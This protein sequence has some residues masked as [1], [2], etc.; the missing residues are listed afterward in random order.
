MG[1]AVTAFEATIE[2]GM[3]N[4]NGSCLSIRFEANGS[5]LLS[6]PDA[7]FRQ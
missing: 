2:I 3:S 1:S 7:Q 4:R 6:S 5:N